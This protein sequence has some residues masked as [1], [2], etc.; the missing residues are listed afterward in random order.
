MTMIKRGT[1]M[2]RITV[3]KLSYTCPNCGHQ[4]VA[5]EDDENGSK[6][7]KC[8]AEMNLVNYTAEGSSE[9]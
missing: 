1:C 6:C 7:P 9:N 2:G 8:G 5:V 4:D 3:S